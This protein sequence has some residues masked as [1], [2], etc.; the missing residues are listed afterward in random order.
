MQHSLQQGHEF[1]QYFYLPLQYSFLLQVV[2]LAEVLVVV[3]R[4]V[5]QLLLLAVLVDRQVLQQGAAD[6]FQ[7]HELVGDVGDEKYLI[8]APNAVQV[9]AVEPEEDNQLHVELAVADREPAPDGQTQLHDSFHQI[10]HLFEV[11]VQLVGQP[12]PIVLV[13]LYRETVVQQQHAVRAPP[14]P[15]VHLGIWV[16]NVIAI[17]LQVK[18]GKLR[19]VVL[20]TRSNKL[21]QC[22][23]LQV[24]SVAHFIL[25]CCPALRFI[26]CLNQQNIFV[27]DLCQGLHHLMCFLETLTPLNKFVFNQIDSCHEMTRKKYAEIF[28]IDFSLYPVQESA[29]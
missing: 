16:E 28:P 12:Y 19:V 27:Q 29:G 15:K 17:C 8:E 3:E 4:L 2:H 22:L 9:P 25:E 6:L 20:G 21:A 23:L 1:L 13:S 26:E 10:G 7:D 24:V 5:P 11:V 14:V 18:L